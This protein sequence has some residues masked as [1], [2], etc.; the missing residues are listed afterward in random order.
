MVHQVNIVAIITTD[1]GESVGKGLPTGKVLRI[2]AETGRHR[3]AARIDDFG[4]GKYQVNQADMQKIIGHFVDKKRR[5]L[6]L[7]ATSVYILLPEIA[8]LTG[9]Q[10]SQDL[11]I[12]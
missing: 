4:I 6:S 11:R 7:N 9:V 1:I 2:A 3:M 5:R 12:A 8:E 10:T